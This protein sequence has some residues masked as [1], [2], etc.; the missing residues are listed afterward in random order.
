MKKGKCSEK[1][2]FQTEKNE[3]REESREPRLGEW[4]SNEGLGRLVGVGAGGGPRK[5]WGFFN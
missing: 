4:G 3:S 1:W 2:A 5:K